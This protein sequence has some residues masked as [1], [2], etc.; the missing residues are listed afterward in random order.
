MIILSEFLSGKIQSLTKEDLANLQ[1]IRM[2][3]FLSGTLISIAIPQTLKE[4]SGSSFPAETVEEFDF[5]EVLPGFLSSLDLPSSP[6][7]SKQPEDFLVAANGQ[8]LLGCKKTTND[9][10]KIPEGI[11]NLCAYCLSSY[12]GTFT[13]F[14]IPEGIEL[15]QN[16]VFKGHT[17]L[18]TLI[19]A[20]SVRYIGSNLFGDDHAEPTTLVFKQPKGMY[21]DL[22]QST[23][24]L[25][26]LFTEDI[27]TEG[28][29]SGNKATYT[30]KIYADN[31]YIREYNWSGD[32]ITPEW[33]TLEE[34]EN[35]QQQEV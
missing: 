6:W 7:F 23:G 32:K 11:T 2:A 27:R 1:R 24:L 31:E 18:K 13:K 10:L 16:C 22:P 34:W 14:V 15:V 28:M 12:G 19:F 30:W 35:E 4:F 25:G 17:T 8:I 5:S 26:S 21:I 29:F 9:D 33:H 3:A 20:P